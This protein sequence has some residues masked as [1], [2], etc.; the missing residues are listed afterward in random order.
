M[1]KLIIVV[2]TNRTNYLD[3]KTIAVIE[4]TKTETVF[5]K[6]RLKKT[7]FN[8]P[9]IHEIISQETGASRARNVGIKYALK[10]Q[11][12]I[13]AFTDDDCIITKE[14]IN[15]IKKSFENSQINII[16]GR[17]LAYKP[18]KHQKEFCPCTFSKVNCE[19]I[20]KIE[21]FWKNVGPSNN[22]AVSRKLIC[23]IKGFDPRFG[24]GTNVFG[25]EDD[26]FTIRSLEN[27][28]LVYYDNNMIVYHNRWLKKKLMRQLTRKY[29][30]SLGCVYGY[31]ALAGNL[32]SKNVLLSCFK[33]Q[34]CNYS[35]RDCFMIIYLI[36]GVLFAIYFLIID[37]SKLGLNKLEW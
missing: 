26:D 9:L 23:K 7:Y 29:T 14:W 11:A 13:F 36:I 33:S 3:Q 17:T 19:P 28:F 24:P 22:M 12:K 21:T 34:F 2:I 25:G 8:H 10:H 6:Q 18:E 32:D 27:G 5:V 31:H 20:N 16:Y 30:L 37:I 15:S 4:E 1:N 35:S